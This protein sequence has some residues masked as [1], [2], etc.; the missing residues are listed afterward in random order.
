[1]ADQSLTIQRAEPT[2]LDQLC[3]LLEANGL[4]SRDVWKKPEC[5]FIS[6]VENHVVGGGGVELCGTSGLVRS[7]VIEE[8]HRGRGYGAVLCDELETH[9]QRSGIETL[10]L[11]TTTAAP[12]F[13]KRGYEETPREETPEPIQET[14]EFTELCPASATCMLKA[15]R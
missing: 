12:F 6:R 7:V 3:I 13:R 9:A 5:F 4:P 14:T 15:F 1:M 2:D 10:Y 8:S 11:L